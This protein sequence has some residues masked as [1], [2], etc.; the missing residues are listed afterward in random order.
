[1]TQDDTCRKLVAQGDPEAFLGLLHDMSSLV[2]QQIHSTLGIGIIRAVPEEN[3]RPGG[4]SL[5][6][7]TACQPVGHP[8][9]VDA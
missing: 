7:H 6:A 3:V 4:K 1:M 5:G 8:P 2:R 9:G